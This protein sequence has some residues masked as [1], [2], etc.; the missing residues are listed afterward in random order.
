MNT[1]LSKVNEAFLENYAKKKEAIVQFENLQGRKNRR[2]KL[3]ELTKAEINRCRVYYTKAHTNIQ[4]AYTKELEKKK[5][6]REKQLLEKPSL[7][8]ALLDSVTVF[9]TKNA[10][11][12]T[13]SFFIKE[14]VESMIEK[15]SEKLL[16]QIGRKIVENSEKI[17]K[18]TVKKGMKHL[19]DNGISLISRTNEEREV[20]EF[21][22]MLYISFN[23]FYLETLEN[24]LIINKLNDIELFAVYKDLAKKN[25][26]VHLWYERSIELIT[27]M[28]DKQIL[29]IGWHVKPQKSLHHFKPSIVKYNWT[30]SNYGVLWFLCNVNNSTSQTVPVLVRAK[31]HRNSNAN[32]KDLVSIYEKQEFTPHSYHYLNLTVE[33]II[34]P[35]LYP[36]GMKK[37]NRV[38]K[39]MQ[40]YALSGK[41]KL[42]K[43]EWSHG[44]KV[45]RSVS[46]I[47]N[48]FLES[49]NKY[50]ETLRKISDLDK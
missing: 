19:E 18:S 30:K 29:P 32:N 6:L 47:I 35:S 11:V 8:M 41:T 27:Y 33:E 36:L 34:H 49:K 40:N 24:D 21:F 10:V 23:K 5:E 50:S 39:Y 22:D 13:V 45:N 3:E 14:I 17:T 2:K 12:K 1:I 26:S 37:H 4:N 25:S 20:K 9:Y 7:I 16:D 15:D 38:F 31:Y 46:V 48:N 28:F 42:I 43:K 44:R